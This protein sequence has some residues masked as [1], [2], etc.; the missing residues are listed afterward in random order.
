MS[1]SKAKDE[2]EQR[3]ILIKA[4]RSFYKITQTKKNVENA[5]NEQKNEFENVMDVL[6][7][8][9][10]DEDGDIYVDSSDEL[11]SGKIKVHK[12]Q[13]SKITWDCK[14]LRRVLGEKDS[15]D[16]I[17]KRYEVINFPLLIKLAK[18][19]KIPWLEFKKCI[20][21]EE[22]VNEKALDKLVDLG[23]ADKDEVKECATVKLNKPYYK[24][25]EK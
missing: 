7:K 3:N 20:D 4:V 10:A 11:D 1:R 9:F 15:E 22:V 18:Q 23:I 13:I 14:K 2:Q 6:Y 12:V 21:Y 16:I 25:T 19:Y 8:R 17:T 24:L 5:F